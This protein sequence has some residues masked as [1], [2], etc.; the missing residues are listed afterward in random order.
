MSIQALVKKHDP[1]IQF[2]V[3]KNYHRQIEFAWTN[4]IDLKGI[5]STKF[6]KII[7]TGLGGSAISGDLLQNFLGEELS[8]P[9]TVNRNYFLPSYADE[10]TL[11]VVSSY[12]GGTEETIEVFEQALKRRCKIIC[13]STGGKVGKIAERNKIPLVKIQPGYQPRFALGLSFFSLLKVMQNLNIIKEQDEIVNKIIEL[14]IKYSSIYSKEDNP[15]LNYAEK[16]IGFIPVIYSCADVTSAVGYRLKCQMNE[17]SKLHAF[18]NV[19]PEMNH[20][21]IIGWETFNENR[22]NAI[23][24]NI[25]DEKYHPQIKRRFHITNELVSKAGVDVINLQSSEENFKVR[26]MDLTYLADWITYYLALLRGYDPSE[27]QYINTLKQ[28]LT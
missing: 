14:W 4:N 23:L 9:F 20:N 17:N 19:I 3:L 1:Q 6:N 16:L 10:S 26:I 18:H 12:S 22:L 21:E 11:I 24:I 2:E 25:L 13:I 5:D 8:L 15:A 28:R 27:I 7:L